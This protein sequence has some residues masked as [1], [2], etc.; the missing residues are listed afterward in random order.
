[1]LNIEIFRVTNTARRHVLSQK[2]ADL[3]CVLITSSVTYCTSGMSKNVSVQLQ[4]TWFQR[5]D[6]VRII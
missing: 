3:R 1:V 4:M 2:S 5:D 6:N